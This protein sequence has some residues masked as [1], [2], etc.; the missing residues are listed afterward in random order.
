MHGGFVRLANAGF[1]NA[2]DAHNGVLLCVPDLKAIVVS[3]RDDADAG[4]AVVHPVPPEDLA[5]KA[6]KNAQA[7][8]VCPYRKIELIGALL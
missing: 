6:V 7:G 1:G 8:V 5:R 4:I 3:V 2:D